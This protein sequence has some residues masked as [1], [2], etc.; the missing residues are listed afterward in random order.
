MENKYLD[1]IADAFNTQMPEQE[2]LESALDNVL[3][4][5]RPWSEDLED[6]DG[7]FFVNRQWMEI[8]DDENFHDIVLYI[9][10]E[11]GGITKIINDQAGGG[12]WSFIANG[13]FLMGNTVYELAFLDAEYFILEK[14][15]NPDLI[16]DRYFV[17]VSENIAKRM[18][19]HDAIELLHNKYKNDNN[20]TNAI[21]VIVVLV[22]ILAFLLS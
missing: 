1:E 5:V 13:K 10:E 6:E 3:K 21:A 9:F 4:E 15:G 20:Y 14:H 11:T 22:I 2:S 18:E 12:S 17:L 8:R 19:W 16:E 7:N